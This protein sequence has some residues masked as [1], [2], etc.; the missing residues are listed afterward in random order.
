[1][2]TFESRFRVRS[3]ELDSFG[4]VNHAVPLHYFEE[5]RWRALEE[6]GF[7][8]SELEAR[9]EAVYVVRIEID[10]RGEARMGERLL[11]R[12]RVESF[13]RSSMTIHQELVRD[14]REPV[15]DGVP[16]GA[17]GGAGAEDLVA[18]AR[19]VAIW[20]GPDG[21]PTRVPDMVREALGAG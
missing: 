6:G 16:D 21:R 13:G 7:P 5:A 12:T 14:G 18:E 1:M 8:A 3:Y 20:I 2:R 15:R 17:G 9:G 10:Y 19:V 4:H 11:A